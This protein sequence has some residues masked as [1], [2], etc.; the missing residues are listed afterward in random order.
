MAAAAAKTRINFFITHRY[1]NGDEDQNCAH[2]AMGVRLIS[3]GSYSLSSRSRN[4]R[5][6]KNHYNQKEE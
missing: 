6:G 2:S 1:N 3:L 5:V 4:C